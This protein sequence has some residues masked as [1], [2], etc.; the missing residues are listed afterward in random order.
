MRNGL[1]QPGPAG[2]E[3][4]HMG[5][6]CYSTW[7]HPPKLIQIRHSMDSLHPNSSTQSNPTFSSEEGKMLLCD[8]C[9]A[10]WYMDCL[11]DLGNAPYGTPLSPHLRLFYDTSTSPTP[12]LTLSLIKH[13][14]A[15]DQKKRSKRNFSLPLFTPCHLKCASR[16]LDQGQ[17][18]GQ[19]TG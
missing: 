6:G 1:E 19:N 13:Y 18:P 4:I 14:T 16:P 15:L 9:N 2:G 5:K 8:I 17:Y 11:L 3:E 7:F 10:G 12:S